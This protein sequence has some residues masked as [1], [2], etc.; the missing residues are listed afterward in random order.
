MILLALQL[1]R[2]STTRDLLQTDITVGGVPVGGLPLSEAVKSWGFVYR[3]PVELDY[4]DSPI[5]LSPAQIGF[6]TKDDQ[7]QGQVQSRSAGTNNYWSDFWNYLW[8]RP[9]TPDDV[10]LAIISKPSCVTTSTIL[11]RV[12]SS[13][14]PE[15]PSI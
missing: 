2:F 7:M 13:A 5:M 15:P 14:P 10:P 12:I 9:A 11:Q 4:G 8:Q 3:Q 6:F 1:A